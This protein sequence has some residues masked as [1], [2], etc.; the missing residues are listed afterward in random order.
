[1]TKQEPLGEFTDTPEIN[2]DEIEA[3]P[4]TFLNDRHC[5]TCEIAVH[6][7]SYYKNEEGWTV[8]VYECPECDQEPTVTCRWPHRDGNK[9]EGR[10][11]LRSSNMMTKS[12]TRPIDEEGGEDE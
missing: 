9:T 11:G 7:T 6:I 2:P 5:E 10:F 8:V 12:P 4:T 1:M 3:V